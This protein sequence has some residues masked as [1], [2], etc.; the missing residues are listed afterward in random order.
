MGD[1]DEVRNAL[2][3]ERINLFGTSYGTRAAQVYMRRFPTRVRSVIMKGVAP[4]GT[5]L[6]LPMAR[7]AQRALDLTFED[8][9]ADEACR[10]AFPDLA[11]KWKGVL[12]ELDGGVEVEISDP[13]TRDKATVKISR[14]TVAP[15]IRSLL[16]GVEGAAQIPMLIDRAANGD[17]APLAEAALSIR[18]GFG[19]LVST[20]MFL[21][22]T[23]AEDIPKSIPDEVARASSGTFLQDYY[24]KQL[25]R[26][27]AIIPRGEVAAGYH[28]PIKSEIPTLLVSGFLDPATP[29]SG[30]DEVGS[31]L[32][33]SLH[34]VARYGS[35]SY[36]GMS[37]CVDN[38]MAEF[39]AR[40]SV[41]GVDTS[42]VEAIRR[43]PF[44]TSS[45][46]KPA[47]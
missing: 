19:K 15:T 27:A 46:K 26:A 42:C 37:P 29:P 22:I 35:H 44:V 30:A 4:I 28:E 43:P 7:D 16:Q 25:Q 33:K 45:E 9:A 40:G 36:G 3:Y 8:C 21:A 20:G 39:I 32:P 14:A 38:I 11:E 10:G 24:F 5:V 1:L 31:H 18:R 13:E 41:E 47:D 6:T 17:Y 2:G 12:S 34:V 23:T